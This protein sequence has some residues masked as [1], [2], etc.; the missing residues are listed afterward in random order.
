MGEA[1]GAAVDD[2]VT[3]ALYAYYDLIR[4][5]QRRWGCSGPP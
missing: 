3:M 1:Y 4:Y 2:A 5:F